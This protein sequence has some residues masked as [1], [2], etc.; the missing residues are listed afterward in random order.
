MQ[1]QQDEYQLTVAI[2]AG[3]AFA[4]GIGVGL[5]LY[6]VTMPSDLTVRDSTQPSLVGLIEATQ[7]T[8]GSTIR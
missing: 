1:S 8:A 3:L 6:N 4:A 2:A 5:Q 7:A